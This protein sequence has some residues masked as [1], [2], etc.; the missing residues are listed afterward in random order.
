VQRSDATLSHEVAYLSLQTPNNFSSK[1]KIHHHP[2]K[3]S[4]MGE[5]DKKI[6]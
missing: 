3:V 2:N 5:L 1:D 4:Q 6:V